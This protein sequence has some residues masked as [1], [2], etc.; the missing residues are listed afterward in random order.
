MGPIP[1]E[2]LPE[3]MTHLWTQKENHRESSGRIRPKAQERRFPWIQIDLLNAKQSLQINESA[4]RPGTFDSIPKL[5]LASGIKYFFHDLPQSGGSPE[6]IFTRAEVSDEAEISW[7]IEVDYGSNLVDP[8]F[9]YHSTPKK[10]HK[11]LSLDPN[12]M[13][14]PIGWVI[15]IDEDFAV[16]W[17][18]LAAIIVIV[19]GFFVFAIIYTAESGQEANG[20]TIVSCAIALV[21]IVFTSWVL[22]SKDS[23]HART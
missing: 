12:G 21:N 6:E 10:L 20:W 8:R 17:L 14:S 3:H 23:K 16:H 11:Q 7:S 15:W 5:R 18:V 13:V 2:G 22:R 9:V 19:F 4:I 1:I